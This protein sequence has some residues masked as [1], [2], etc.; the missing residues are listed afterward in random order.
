MANETYT[1]NMNLPT[2]T[3]GITDGP[4]FA[5]D[6]NNSLTLL[7]QHSH[8]PGSGVPIT[9]SALDINLD[10]PL[11]SNNLTLARS[12]RF[13]P[14]G[15]ALSLPQDLGCLYEVGVDLYYNDGAGNPIRITQSG[16]ITGTSGSIANLVAPASASYI[17]LSQTFVFQSASNTAANMDVASLLLRNSTVN[18]FALTLNPP[19][20]MSANYSLVLP[21]LPAAKN[22]MTLDSAGN[23]SAVWNVD[24]STIVVTANK[25]TAVPDQIATNMTPAGAQ[26]IATTM[27]NT[28]AGIIGGNFTSPTIDLIAS[29]FSATAADSVAANMD[30]TGTTSIANT[31]TSANAQTIG[32]KMTATG[33]NAISASITGVTS[34][35][36]NLYAA[37]M[38]STGT[39]SIISTMGAAGADAI[40]ANMDTTGVS[41]IVTTMTPTIAS[42]LGNKITANTLS[43]GVLQDL[44]VSP[45]KIQNSSLT[46]TQVAANINLPGKGVQAAGLHVVVSNTNTSQNLAIIR[47]GV[48]SNGGPSL[49]EGFTSSIITTGQYSIVFNTP[50][51]D[52]PSVT[53]NAFITPAYCVV[54]SLSPTGFTF[55]TVQP[56]YDYANPPGV[57]LPNVNSDCT[58]IVIGERA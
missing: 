22:I 5:T 42:T 58:F 47:G 20:A 50:F 57:L 19:S 38:T 37:G 43:G 39:S 18:S 27:G 32:Q 34:S 25:F 55:A 49:G 3:V 6:I 14:Q 31:M 45:S 56:V 29:R 24:N 36:S 16:S 28:G 10:L 21:A 53:V 11:N 48:A 54:T 15:S 33:A 4:Q 8:T 52:N 23:M 2:P 1:P 46:G 26:T 41:S 17:A 35:T 51:A 44:T 9:P 7:D 30:S 40:A 13:S 12:V